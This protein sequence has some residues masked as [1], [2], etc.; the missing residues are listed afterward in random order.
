M[1]LPHH[2]APVRPRLL[3]RKTQAPFLITLLDYQYYFQLISLFPCIRTESLVHSGLSKFLWVSLAL[4][5][6]R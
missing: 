5:F 1:A 4:L 2:P 6:I 3:L